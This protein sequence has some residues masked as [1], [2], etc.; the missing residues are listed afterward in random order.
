MA[1][2]L[3]QFRLERL[4]PLGERLQVMSQPYAAHSAWRYEQPAFGEFVSNPHLAKRRL[5]DRQL[6]NRLFHVRLGSVLQRHGLRRLISFSASSPPFSY[7]SL[8]R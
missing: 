4:Q 5:F 3:R 6:H 1:W 8:N 7:S 2:F